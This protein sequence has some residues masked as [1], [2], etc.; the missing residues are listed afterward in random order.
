MVLERWSQCEAGRDDIYPD[1]QRREL[2]CQ[3]AAQSA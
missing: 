1:A 2:T 3:R